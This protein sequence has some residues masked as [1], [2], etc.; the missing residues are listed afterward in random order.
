MIRVEVMLAWPRRCD[1][2][3]VQLPDGARLQDAVQASGLDHPAVV[4][5][6]IH[7]VRAQGD[8]PLRD[9]DRV[10][11][12]RAL[13]ADPKDARRKRARDATRSR[14]PALPSRK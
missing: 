5:F 1:A 7:G 12:L 11:L 4:A 6:A 8:T 10:E 14:P 2:V 3:A 9:G 13:L